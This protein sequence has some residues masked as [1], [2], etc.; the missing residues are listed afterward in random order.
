MKLIV[1]YANIYFLINVKP[2]I[3]VYTSIKILCKDYS[4]KNSKVALIARIF[5][6]RPSSNNNKTNNSKIIIM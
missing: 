2:K 5:S 6:N 3:N 4:L 1:N